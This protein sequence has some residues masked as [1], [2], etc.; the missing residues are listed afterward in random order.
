MASSGGGALLIVDGHFMVQRYSAKANHEAPTG[1]TLL[2]RAFHRRGPAHGSQAST[3]FLDIR[4]RFNFRSI[5]IGRWVTE[6]EKLR[7]ATLF[8]DA[9][10]D[11]MAILSGPEALI[12]LR[13]TLALQYGTGG[14]RGVAAHYEPATHTF[15]LAKNAG[16]GSIAH[17][18]FHAFDH[19]ICRKAF[20]L[21]G[22]PMRFGSKAWLDGAPPVSHPLNELLRNCYR[23]VLVNESGQA[24]SE[25]F[26]Q[27]ALQDERLG[28]I[29]YTLPEELCARAFEAF[30]QDAPIKN[31]FLVQG[32]RQSDEARLGLYPQGDQR[33]RINAAFHQYFTQL[34]R[35]LSQ[36]S[37]T[38][39]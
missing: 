11:L 10:C 18:W 23:T 29:Y 4:R 2:S 30:V 32:T 22:A 7:A 13:G 37:G 8:H 26:R 27:S 33:E 21:E 39:S 17:E 19:Y 9:L 35:A 20:A 1:A 12:S 3:S 36:S 5:A 38:N 15:A 16:P 28:V 24:P 6:P 34:G 31:G 14:Q 25:L